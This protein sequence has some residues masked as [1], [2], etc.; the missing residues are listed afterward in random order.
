MQLI[1]LVNKEMPD[2][3]KYINIGNDVSG[4]DNGVEH[5]YSS[6]FIIFCGFCLQSNT[7]TILTI[8]SL[9]L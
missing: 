9:N 8:L 5:V 2:P 6:N 3:E 1:T 4:S 7:E